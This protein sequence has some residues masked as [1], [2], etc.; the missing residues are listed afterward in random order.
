MSSE[1]TPRRLLSVLE[2][3]K[4]WDDA[5]LQWLCLFGHIEV[6]AEGLP[7]LQTEAGAFS[8]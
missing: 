1:V 3:S 7:I 8:P 6:V 2:A 5:C 4:Q